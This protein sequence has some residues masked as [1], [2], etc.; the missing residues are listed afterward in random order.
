MTYF[1][2]ISY[3]YFTLYICKQKLRIKLNSNA[4]FIRANSK[5]LELKTKNKN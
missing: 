2:K 5:N 3:M 1:I 4:Y